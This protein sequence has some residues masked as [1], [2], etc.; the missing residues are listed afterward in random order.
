VTNLPIAMVPV[1]S[2]HPDDSPL[3]LTDL[4]GRSQMLALFE[5]LDRN[6][7]IQT[8][9]LDDPAEVLAAET[10]LDPATQKASAD[11]A[12]LVA[13]LRSSDLLAWV[14]NTWR[15]TESSELMATMSS[16]HTHTS[17]N[18]SSST[19]TSASMSM[20]MST[21]FATAGVSGKSSSGI[22]PAM[23]RLTISQIMLRAHRAGGL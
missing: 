19:S 18:I 2:A 21:T 3:V 7:D 11:N 10:G 8:R 17:T 9:F 13:L 5:Q 15:G 6:S 22:D 16:M 4:I 20:S 1:T 12:L 23:L 14:L